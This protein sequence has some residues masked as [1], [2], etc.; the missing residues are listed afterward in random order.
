M[1]AKKKRR[2][3]G[4]FCFCCFSC[5]CWWPSGSPSGRCFSGRR[6]SWCR[7]TPP[8]QQEQHAED[9]GDSDEEKLTQTQGGGAVS[10]TYTSQVS[11]SLSSGQA[12]LYFANPS[13]SNQDIV[14]QIVA[15]DV[16][17][18][19]S[20]TISPG[21]Q[22]ETLEL[23]EG[24]AAQLSPGGYNGRFVVLYYQPDTHEKTIVNTEI[25]VNIT[26]EP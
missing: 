11:I 15:Q 20:G 7:I 16:V 1:S 19:Q 8:R 9:I 25:P 6:P 22:V 2:I 12:T 10:L 26:V 21:K 24:V 14:L 5:C 17:L 4:G 13:K 3:S 18:A 23:W